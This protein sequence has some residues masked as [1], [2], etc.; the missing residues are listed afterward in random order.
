MLS[1]A[2]AA[3]DD[4]DATD[5]DEGAGGGVAELMVVKVVAVTVVAV[6]ESCGV[7]R[8]V[9]VVVMA[10][11]VVVAAEAG[12]SVADADVEEIVGDGLMIISEVALIEDETREDDIDSDDNDDSVCRI[13]VDVATTSTGRL[14]VIW[15]RLIDVKAAVSPRVE[16]G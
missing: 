1:T 11:M 6:E 8:G 12:V 3:D 16:E 4:D 2:A 9:V 13:S 5:E 14:L 7:A 15:T 10:R